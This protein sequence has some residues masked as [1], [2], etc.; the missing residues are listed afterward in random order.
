MSLNLNVNDNAR[1]AKPSLWIFQGAAVGWLVVGVM[2]FVTLVTVLARLGADWP[3][4][5]VISLLPLGA[6]TVFV[7][8]FVNGQPPSH[9][10]DLFALQMWRVRSSWYLHRLLDRPPQLWVVRRP[11]PHPKEFA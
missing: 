3:S 6:I 4:A 8:F 10:L 2:F 11:P 5:T 7:H 9:A 1:E